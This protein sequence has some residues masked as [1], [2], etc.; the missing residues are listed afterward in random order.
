MFIEKHGP[1][2]LPPTVQSGTGKSIK[3]QSITFSG[4][5]TKVSLLNVLD[6]VRDNGVNSPGGQGKGSPDKRKTKAEQGLMRIKDLKHFQKGTATSISGLKGSPAHAAWDERKEQELE[7]LSRQFEDRQICDIRQSS[8][9]V[10]ASERMDRAEILNPVRHSSIGQDDLALRGPALPPMYSPVP[11]FRSEAHSA[12]QERLGYLQPACDS[13]PTQTEVA[14]FE[15]KEQFRI[16]SILSQ[17]TVDDSQFALSQNPTEVSPN[18]PRQF[19]TET[20]R[21]ESQFSPPVLPDPFAIE[22]DSQ[23]R[24]PNVSFHSGNHTF[25]NQ[26]FSSPDFSPQVAVPTSVR[27]QAPRKDKRKASDLDKSPSV[28]RAE[29]KKRKTLISPAERTTAEIMLDSRAAKNRL[30][31]AQQMHENLREQHQALLK[32]RQERLQV[33][34]HPCF[35]VNY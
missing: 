28:I 24:N 29:Q 34:V 12:S 14:D 3:P 21:R 32:T 16:K 30:S 2:V 25:P 26:V 5:Q 15:E 33:N 10:G 20:P 8:Q 17:T 4:G 1:Q 19:A 27:P 11:K 22:K 6:K 18:L 35:V 31:A 23:P 9:P 13:S 7:E